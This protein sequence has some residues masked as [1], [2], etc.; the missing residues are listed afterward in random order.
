VKEIISMLYKQTD[1]SKSFGVNMVAIAGGKP[2]LLGLEEIIQYYVEYQRN[3]I[4]KR[5]TFELNQAKESEEIHEGL[6]IAID[7]IDE[8]VRIIRK[9]SSTAEAR[10]TLRV[11]FALTE[12]QANAILDMRLRRLCALEVQEILDKLAELR[13]QIAE[14]TSIVGSE[15]R[16]LEVVADE[17]AAIK[18]KYRTPRRTRIAASAE[19]KITEQLD[20]EKVIVNGNVVLHDN[21][22]LKFI[23]ARS[24]STC[25]KDLTDP[26]GVVSQI[27]ACT[28][29]MQL[30]VFT[31]NG[32]FARM[33]VRD[34]KERKLKEKGFSLGKLFPKAGEDKPVGFVIA[35]DKSIDNIKIVAVVS[36]GMVRVTNLNEYMTRD[37]FGPAIKLKSEAEK[38]VMTAVY[39]ENADLI[40]AGEKGNVLR[41]ALN[42]FMVKGRLTMGAGAIKLDDDDRVISAFVVKEDPTILAVAKSGRAKIVF[43]H[44]FGVS[45]KMRKG[46]SVMQDLL[47]FAPI[48]RGETIAAFLDEDMMT[49]RMEDVMLSDIYDRGDPL[50]RKLGAKITRVVVHR[51]IN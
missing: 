31:A 23:S 6:K 13:R 2:K 8:V 25:A 12:K 11:R 16:Q 14:L 17:L 44:E 51:I 36:D 19:I 49:V 33:T 48:A 47:C 24:F 27:E 46:T 50:V 32:N 38:V 21:G 20:P 30:F 29:D 45:E 9:A 5:S 15:K 35:D 40:L 10:S 22:T 37:D 34:L 1:L 4:K 39:D 42:G 3:V 43:A 28:N 26:E 41:V 7:N 18:R